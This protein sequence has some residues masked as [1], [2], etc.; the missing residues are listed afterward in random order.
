MPAMQAFLDA[1]FMATLTLV[2]ASADI[3]IS[4]DI[5]AFTPSSTTGN[6]AR[7]IT[8]TLDPNPTPNPSFNGGCSPCY[9]GGETW[10]QLGTWEEI[11]AA[12]QDSRIVKGP[13]IPGGYHVSYHTTA[14]T[15]AILTNYVT[16][17]RAY[18]GERPLFCL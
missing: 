8:I 3:I 18:Q 11:S 10:D 2:V 1:I 5:I 6:T 4:D 13:R 15:G 7:A 17:S 12:L 14:R 16:G 9:C